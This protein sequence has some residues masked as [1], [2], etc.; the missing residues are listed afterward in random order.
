MVSTEHVIGADIRFSPGFRSTHLGASQWPAAVGCDPYQEPIELYE[1]YMGLVPWDDGPNDAAELGHALEDFVAK[2]AARRLEQTIGPCLT[3][4]HS[5]YP[6]AVATPDRLVADGSSLQV[7]TTG[8]LTRGSYLEEW[9][10]EGTDEV[11]QRVLVQVTGEMMI[12]RDF[13]RNNFPEAPLCTHTHVAA[14]VGQ[15]GVLLY[16]VEWDE[17]LA[18]M[19]FEEVSK[20]WG[21]VT[22][23]KALPPDSSE[24]FG[25]YIGRRYPSHEKGQWLDADEALTANIMGLRRARKEI[26]KWEREERWARNRICD[27]IGSAEG[28]K[29]PWGS[30]AWRGVKGREQLDTKGLLSDLRTKYG[31][32]IDELVRRNTRRG[33]GYRAFKPTFTTE[34]EI[35]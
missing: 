33:S 32:E 8:L 26:E 28:I 23:K 7:K 20:F 17:D 6:W 19:L 30:I 12:L 35:P 5:R 14:F 29:G 13:T 1:K 25:A 21:H 4:R 34:E 16:R 2:I 24:A 22:S 11:P 27:A 18:R 3:L 15:R 31:P 10:E 9:G